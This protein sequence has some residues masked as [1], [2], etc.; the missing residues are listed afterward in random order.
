MAA[1]T[2]T[3]NQAGTFLCCFKLYSP[4]AHFYNFYPERRHGMKIFTG[5]TLGPG[6]QI[7]ARRCSQRTDRGAHQGA[8]PGEARHQ[9]RVHRRAFRV[10]WRHLNQAVLVYASKPHS[11]LLSRNQADFQFS[12]GHPW[13]PGSQAAG[14]G[15]DFRESS[16]PSLVTQESLHWRRLGSWPT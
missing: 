16:L 10:P 4:R 2:P 5:C 9:L 14:S 6:A 12:K 7:S 11:S 15:G 13:R 1:P 3:H 8:L